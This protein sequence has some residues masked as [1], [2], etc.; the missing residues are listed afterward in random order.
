MTTVTPEQPRNSR[1][2]AIDLFCGSGGV[3]LGLRHAGF[4]VLGAVDF[5]K[6]ACETYRTNHPDVLLLEEDIQKVSP[7]QF[8]KLI[9]KQLDLLA[10]CAPCQP[11][12]SQ[13]KIRSS[14]DTRKELILAAIPFVKKLKPKA[15]FVENVPGL[16]RNSVFDQFIASLKKLG[17]SVSEPLKLNASHLGVPQRRTRMVMIATNGISLEVASTLPK[18]KPKTVRSVIGELP[19]PTIGMT[20]NAVDSLHFARRHSPLNI[21]RLRHIPKDGGGRDALPLHLQLECHKNNTASSFSDT[22]GRMKW[23]DVA[24]TLTTGCTDIT[25]G[26]FA[27]PEQNRAITLREA[28]RLQSFP[29]TY[30][31]VGGVSAISAQIGNAVPPEMMRTIGRALRKALREAQ[32]K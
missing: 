1:L 12:S 26:R 20:G 5:D 29:D 17:Y 3:S 6:S 25:R 31:F 32:S 30:Q 27:H 22:Y 7:E 28:A 19:P 8:E 23:D 4:N 16:K 24:P 10:I 11:F 14:H 15:I 9:E 13:N 21:E 2:T 18:R